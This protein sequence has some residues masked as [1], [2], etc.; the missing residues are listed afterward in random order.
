FRANGTG[1]DGQRPLPPRSTTVRVSAK[2]LWMPEAFD[3]AVHEI[4]A[5]IADLGFRVSLPRDWNLPDLPADEVDCG[6]AGAFFP[7][8]MAVAPWAAVVLTIAARPG[9][10]DGTLQD[11]TLFLLDSQGIKPKSFGLVNIGDL[12]GLAGVGRQQ[13]EGTWL[14]VRFA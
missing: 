10:G 7:L 8:V 11:W 9:F 13:Q 14:D 4:P 1:R 5:R 6:S 3:F 12:Q 2:I